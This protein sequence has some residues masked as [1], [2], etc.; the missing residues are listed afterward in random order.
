MSLIQKEVGDF[1]VQA[2]QNNAFRTVTRADILGKWNVFFFYPAYCPVLG[3]GQR[4]GKPGGRT[5]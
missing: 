5:G 1:S 3:H 2:F 4:N